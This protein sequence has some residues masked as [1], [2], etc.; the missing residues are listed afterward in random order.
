MEKEKSFEERLEEANLSL[1]YRD[2]ID[3]CNIYEE[4]IEEGFNAPELYNNYG[5]TLFYLD[6][7][8]DA[9]SQFEKAISL[10]SSFALAYANIG[11]L[12]LNK[13][14]LGKAAEYFL[15]ALQFDE[16]NPETHYNLAV[17][18]YR[19]NKKLEALKHYEYFLSFAGEEYKKLKESVRNIIAQIKDFQSA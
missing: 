19:L 5:L 3:A 9:L 8:D 1:R 15:K 12:Y 16:K 7:F 4:L 14:E 2:Y 13:Q 17:T 10:D 18:Y 11:L 6:K